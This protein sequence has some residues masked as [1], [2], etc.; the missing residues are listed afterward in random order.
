MTVRNV[1]HSIFRI[2]SKPRASPILLD[3]VFNI[4]AELLQYR[5]RVHNLFG[6]A[7]N[8]DAPLVPIHFPPSPPYGGRQAQP[9][10]RSRE[11]FERDSSSPRQR[12]PKQK[13]GHGQK[14]N[15]NW[16]KSGKRSSQD[17]EDTP[18]KKKSSKKK[19]R[20]SKDGDWKPPKK[21]S[22]SSE[23]NGRPWR[24]DSGG[25]QKKRRFS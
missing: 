8:S 21:N 5:M 9:L 14:I 12:T 20:R 2:L 3:A 25:D 17:E 16:K 23:G 22:H 18:S 15:E 13:G 7:V 10:K 1:L 11:S 6:K 19:Q 24:R 4:D